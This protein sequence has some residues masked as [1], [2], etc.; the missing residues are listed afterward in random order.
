MVDNIIDNLVCIQWGVS[1][2]V[3][4]KTISLPISMATQDYSVQLQ[5]G[6]ARDIGPLLNFWNCAGSRTVSSFKVKASSACTIYW[7]AIGY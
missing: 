7:L 3:S 2:E 5:L 6:Y 1:Y 4:D